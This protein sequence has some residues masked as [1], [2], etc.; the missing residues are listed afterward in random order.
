MALHAVHQDS[1]P[2][3]SPIHDYDMHAGSLPSQRAGWAGTASGGSF[4]FCPGKEANYLDT[5]VR[6]VL[7]TLAV[8]W[9]CGLVAVADWL[10]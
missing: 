6:V 10:P 4:L 9:R 7:T 8:C 3:Q 1:I 2:S 5:R